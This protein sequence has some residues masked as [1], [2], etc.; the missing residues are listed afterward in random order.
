MT[1]LWGSLIGLGAWLVLRL[2][3]RPQLAP[4]SRYYVDL[5]QRKCVPSPFCFRLFWPAVLWWLRPAGWQV[6]VAVSLAVQGA[7]MSTLAGTPIAAVLLFGLPAGAR[8]SVRC[9]MLVDAPTL[10]AV[11]AAAAWLPHDWWWLAAGGFVVGLMRA[12]AAVWL[13]ILVGSR[14]PVLLVG[15]AMWLSALSSARTA[16]ADHG[17]NLWITNPLG[18]AL[19]ARRG[20]WLNPGLMVLPWGVV[21][22]LAL[23]SPSW[24]L[25]GVLALGYLPLV[26]VSDTARAY[27]WAAPAVILIALQAPVPEWAWPWLLVAHWC[28]P[29][30]GA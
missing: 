23:L 20:Q 29:Y 15:W 7:A 11:L 22:P 1:T 14:L 4:D 13:A 10:A 19:R 12:D 26:G 27:H 21:L 25:V 30:R 24:G 3:E 28:N 6:V 16:S 18:T 9:P 2:D 5:Q 8:F 17:D